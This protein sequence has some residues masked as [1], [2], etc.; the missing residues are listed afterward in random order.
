MRDLPSPTLSL[1]VERASVS[2]RDALRLMKRMCAEIDELYGNP[3]AS[4]P[5]DLAGMDAPGAVF[6][7]ARASGRAVG[8]AAL[9]PLEATTAEVKRMYV[10]PA[11][12]KQGLAREIMRSLEEIAR[13]CGFSAI[14]LETGQRQPGAIRLYESLGYKRIAAYGDYKDD[15][16]SVCFGKSLI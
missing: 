16:V 4:T 15:P 10:V 3:P 8:C 13:E 5:F 1:K 9:R 2:S 12:R 6:V 11:A 7:V 14:W